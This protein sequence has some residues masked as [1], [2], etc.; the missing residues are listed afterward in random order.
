MLLGRRQIAVDAE[1]DSAQ[2]HDGVERHHDVAG[3]GQADSHDVVPPKAERPEGG[4]GPINRLIEFLVAQP[5]IG[6]DQRLVLGLGGKCVLEHIADRPRRGTR[7]PSH[8]PPYW[9]R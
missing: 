1:P 8:A 2:P 3:V 5:G 4:G 7:L 9:R 6:G